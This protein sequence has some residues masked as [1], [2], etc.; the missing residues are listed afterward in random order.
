MKGTIERVMLYAQW[1]YCASVQLIHS[2]P[3]PPHTQLLYWSEVPP[4]AELVV[5]SFMLAV[6]HCERW[7]DGELMPS[8]SSLPAFRVKGEILNDV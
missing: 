1:S 8:S 6:L 7:A 4:E 5:F 3:P 2:L